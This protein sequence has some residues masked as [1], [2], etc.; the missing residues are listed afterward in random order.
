VL[1]R[2]NPTAF[3]LVELLVVIAVVALLASLLLPALARAKSKAHQTKCLSNLRQ[4]GFAMQ[5]RLADD[6]DR[7]PDR[8]DLKVSLGYRPWV[9]WP[10]SDPRVGWAAIVFSNYLGNGS[11]W[12]CPSADLMPFRAAPHV[13]QESRPG[14]VESNV[15]YWSWRFDRAVDPVP[16]DNFWGKTIEQSVRDFAA[17]GAPLAA[18]VNGPSD[19][20]LAVDPY[21]PS[22]IASTPPKLRGRAVHRGGRNRLFGDAHVEF[23]RDPRTS[24]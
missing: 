21:F 13:N 6:D 12:R 24:L 17:S 23:L 10:P 4:I 16:L 14:D 20:E 15:T 8:R 2:G 11:V 18:Q 9:S 19:L 1:R 22:S 5:M 3:T 7:F